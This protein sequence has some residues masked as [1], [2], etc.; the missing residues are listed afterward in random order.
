MADPLPEFV[1]QSVSADLFQAGNL[2]F[3]VYTDRLSGWTVVHQWRHLPSSKEVI[4]AIIGDFVDLGIPQWFRS[5]C[6][7]QFSSKTC[8]IHVR[9]H[10]PFR[11][12]SSAT[13]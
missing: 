4:R 9:P 10:R 1:F 3:L 7:T 8:E 6:G 13:S 2:Y 12:R 11:S 5:D